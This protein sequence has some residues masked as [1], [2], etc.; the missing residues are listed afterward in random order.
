M[1]K[2][3]KM[4]I[5]NFMSFKDATIDMDGLNVVLGTNNSG[6]SNFLEVLTFFDLLMRKNPEQAVNKMGGIDRI[7]NLRCPDEKEIL[8]EVTF[9]K[10]STI[11]FSNLKGVKGVNGRYR[12]DFKNS[13]IILCI[14]ISST[15]IDK[16]IF[17]QTF[18]LSGNILKTEVSVSKSEVTSLQNQPSTFSNL[19]FENKYY[20]QNNNKITNTIQNGEKAIQ[21]YVYKTTSE[22]RL[23]EKNKDTEIN[24]CIDSLFSFRSNNGSI[25]KRKSDDWQEVD[26][27][28]IDFFIGFGRS[29][30]K[31]F[32]KYYFLPSNI[33]S[34][35]KTANF[36]DYEGLCLK[37]VLLN[38]KENNEELFDIITANS[39]AMVDEITNIDVKKLSID[40]IKMYFKE[41]GLPD[42][43]GFSL[44]VVS[45]GTVHLLAIL[46]VLYEPTSKSII[47]FEEPE[48]HLHL[49][50]LES[51]MNIFKG[52]SEKKAQ[53]V[54][55]SHSATLMDLCL[56][57][58]GNIIMLYRDGDGNTDTITAKD[59]PDLEE[60]LKKSS[61]RLS[62]VIA[63][64]YL[65]Y[66][67]KFNDRQ[68]EE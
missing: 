40:Y 23:G 31:N 53:I 59:I 48:R 5:K 15:H 66:L 2:I 55:T 4:R 52:Y 57:R 67:G 16:P 18:N 36:M 19:R 7:K 9:D 13:K 56:E 68:D 35:S 28:I 38:I 14:N 60:K 8:I 11:G 45:D 26:G 20:V 62:D 65:G 37:S 17:L 25:D 10:T 46:T 29:G 34:T 32:F 6:K 21:P 27:E 24:E 47:A 54:L 43:D 12:I 61:L 58:K 39:T 1:F 42:E 63:E 64:D 22:I 49:K 51:L 50:A 3:T 33:K 30:F 44:Q 41:K